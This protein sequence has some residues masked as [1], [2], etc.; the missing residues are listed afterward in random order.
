[1]TDREARLVEP[2]D[3]LLLTAG[4]ALSRPGSPD[5]RRLL[6]AS[7]D[8]ATAWRKAYRAVARA[9]SL[10]RPPARDDDPPVPPARLPYRD[11]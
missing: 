11:D 7:W 4:T 6:R 9:E 2:L 3:D 8:R 1:M 10:R 5:A